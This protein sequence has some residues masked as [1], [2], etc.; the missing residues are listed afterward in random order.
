M[1]IDLSQ[2]NTVADL[3]KAATQCDGII[4]RLGIRGYSAGKLKLDK[5]FKEWAKELARLGKLR[6][7]YF[8][9]Q[10]VSTAEAEEEALYCIRTLEAMG[11]DLRSKTFGIFCDSEYANLLH[12]GRADRLSRERRTQY[13]NAFCNRLT[14]AGYKTGVYCAESWAKTQLDRVKIS[15]PFWIA[16]YG[17]NNGKQNEKPG[18]KYEMWQYTSKGRITGIKGNVDMSVMC[19]AAGSSYGNIDYAP[20]FDAAYYADKYPD[21]KA[22]FGNDVAALLEHFARYG[23]QEGRRGSAEFDPVAYRKRY[24]DLRDVFGGDWTAYYLHYIQHGK[25]EGRIAD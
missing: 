16:K 10:A 4:L 8:V 11:L 18:V 7:V 24:A 9:T 3:R 21:L 20:V 23:M 1:I 15:Y 5:R 2:Y 25:A 14:A 22:A 13:V 12:T 19:S 6:G 17:K